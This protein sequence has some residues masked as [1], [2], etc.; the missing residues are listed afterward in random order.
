[1]CCPGGAVTI[2]VNVSLTL[3]G[4]NAVVA[5]THALLWKFAGLKPDS[6]PMR[7]DTSSTVLSGA[8]K[9]RCGT[10][11]WRSVNVA[12]VGGTVVGGAVVGGAVVGGAVV[13]GRVVGGAVVG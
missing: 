8:L 13:G 1:M 9:Q 5:A 2:T 6:M 12:G 4:L 11:S 3:R 7:T 10:R